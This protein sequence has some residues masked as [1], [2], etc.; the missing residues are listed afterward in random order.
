MAHAF[1]VR[2]VL[3]PM[4]FEDTLHEES[5]EVN[6]EESPHWDEDTW[7]RLDPTKVRQ[8]RECEMAN[9]KQRGVK[10]YVR[11]SDARSVI[12]GKSIGRRWVQRNKGDTV[13]CRS[14][15]Q[16]FGNG[17]RGTPPLFAARL[18]VSR[19]GTR[20]TRLVHRVAS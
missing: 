1:E 2:T 7:R 19:V 12:G 6:N 20:E 10:T 4:A 9:F 17:D 13:G 14:V 3:E 15:A 16:E 8:G 18:L 5:E 11:R